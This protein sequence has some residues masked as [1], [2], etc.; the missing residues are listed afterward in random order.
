MPSGKGDGFQGDQR[1]WLLQRVPQYLSKTAW[2]KSS[3]GG[4]APKDDDD[5]QTWIDNRRQEFEIEFTDAIQAEIDAEKTTAVRFREV[6]MHD[7]HCR[8]MV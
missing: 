2:G 3:L 5:L 7:S 4:T 8:S 6:R 1:T